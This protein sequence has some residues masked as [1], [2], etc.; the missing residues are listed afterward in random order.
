MLNNN[1]ELQNAQRKHA[2]ELAKAQQLLAQEKTEEKQLIEEI[3]K[4][5]AEI[6]IETKKLSEDTNQLRTD[7]AKL[8]ALQRE[9]KA[10]E[11]ELK[12]AHDELVQEEQQ[13]RTNLKQAGVKIKPTVQ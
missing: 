3:A 6:P 8:P 2:Q 10:H 9:E 1:A 13:M 4:L 7:R 5:N 12:R 11:Q